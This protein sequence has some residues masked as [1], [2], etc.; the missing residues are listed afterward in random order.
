V[1]FVCARCVLCGDSIFNPLQGNYKKIG[2]AANNVFRS[3]QGSFDLFL[4]CY[5]YKRRVCIAKSPRKN[6]SI[7]KDKYMVVDM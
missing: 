1:S 2:C 7:L 4:T 6:I 5:P 3:M